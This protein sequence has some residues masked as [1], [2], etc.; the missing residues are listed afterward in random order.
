MH[1]KAPSGESAAEGT[2]KAILKLPNKLE[3]SRQTSSSQVTEYTDREKKHE[4]KARRR[5]ST[6]YYSPNKAAVTSSVNI[7]G[8]TASSQISTESNNQ[9]FNRIFDQYDKMQQDIQQRKTLANTNHKA[10]SID[11]HEFS[12]KIKILEHNQSLSVS[13][14]SKSKSNL[15]EVRASRNYSRGTIQ[16]LN[17]SETSKFECQGSNDDQLQL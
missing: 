9:L 15:R 13:T 4:H 12:A 2:T 10:L 14:N 3:T 7:K 11:N 1:S 8:T 17:S 16:I 6:N 5:R